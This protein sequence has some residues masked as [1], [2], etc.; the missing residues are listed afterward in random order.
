MKTTTTT[1]KN[2]NKNTTTYDNDNNNRRRKRKKCIESRKKGGK[3]C[4]HWILTFKSILVARSKNGASFVQ[5][6]FLQDRHLYLKGT[7]H[8][9]FIIIIISYW[10][11]AAFCTQY[12]SLFLSLSQEIKGSTA[13]NKP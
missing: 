10:E 11:K 1:N 3:L 13:K 9:S 5:S 4:V 12:I 7:A 2:K 6:I 8:T